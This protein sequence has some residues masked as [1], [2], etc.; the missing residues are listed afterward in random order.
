MALRQ[1]F[2]NGIE[3]AMVAVLKI[4]EL[5]ALMEDTERL[6]QCMFE[7]GRQQQ[8]KQTVLVKIFKCSSLILKILG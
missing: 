5:P 3:L 8:Q 2:G 6:L 4:T 7:N 1:R